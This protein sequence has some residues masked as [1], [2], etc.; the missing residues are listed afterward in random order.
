MDIVE[1]THN[2]LVITDCALLPSPMGGN[3]HTLYAQG[4]VE[5]EPVVISFPPRLRSF[6]LPEAVALICYEAAKIKRQ[7]LAETMLCAMFGENIGKRALMDSGYF[8]ELA[9]TLI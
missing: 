5:E 2:Q 1:W 7:D 9:R 6:S 8:K 3:A 4:T